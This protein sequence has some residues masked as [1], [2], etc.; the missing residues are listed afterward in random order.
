MRYGLGL[1]FWGSPNIL[2]PVKKKVVVIWPIVV[3][4]MMGEMAPY[5]VKEA[6]HQAPT[7]TILWS[8]TCNPWL[9]AWV[10][11]KHWLRGQDS[12]GNFRRAGSRYKTDGAATN[13][14]LAS[15]AQPR[16]SESFGTDIIHR[17]DTRCDSWGDKIVEIHEITKHATKHISFRSNPEIE[18]KVNCFLAAGGDNAKANLLKSYEHC[19]LYR[20]MLQV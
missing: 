11:G 18:R 8:T 10:T 4:E 17:M 1:D 20:G 6:I 13:P 3:M 9:S 15:G 7:N 19:T 2:A 14:H 16:T 12:V 5:G